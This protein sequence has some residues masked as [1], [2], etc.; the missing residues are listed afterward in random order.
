V[1]PR[2]PAPDAVL[3]AVDLQ[4]SRLRRELLARRR[5]LSAPVCAAVAAA[6]ADS[7]RE[8][9]GELA[10]RRVA[11]CWPVNNEPDL[12]PLLSDWSD[13]AAPGFC[14]LLPVV[15][16]STEPLAFRAWNPGK[17]GDP[18]RAADPETPLAID[19]HG[20]PYPAAGDFVVPEALLIPVNAVDDAGFRLGYGGGYFDRTLA[21]LSPVSAPG[22]RPLAI[23]VGFDFARVAS[24][25]PQAHDVPLDA[26]VTEAG[27]FRF[28]ASS[29]VQR[30]TKPGL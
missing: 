25:W 16:G 15:V 7:L 17:S 8:H 2:S 24:V 13:A 26:L 18:R 28:G 11:F 9:F 20:I 4:R 21:A 1:N 30:T 6:I 27:V 10:A 5:S 23:G 19:R 29:C 3:A 12:R 14:A 22:Q